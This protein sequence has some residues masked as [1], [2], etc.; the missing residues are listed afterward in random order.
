MVII[1][2][3]ILMSIVPEFSL[4]GRGALRL[5]QL[6]LCSLG[7][8]AQIL[9]CRK[10]IHCTLTRNLKETDL[11]TSDNSSMHLEAQKRTHNGSI[12]YTQVSSEKCFEIYSRSLLCFC[13][14]TFR[15]L[16][17]TNG[18]R[19]SWL[20][21]H[22]KVSVVSHWNIFRDQAA[23]PVFNSNAIEMNLH[24]IAN[25]TQNYIYMNDDL[26]FTGVVKNFFH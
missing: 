13:F 21:N 14:V 5:A 24:R 1:T 11:P 22:D 19:P 26:A 16:K 20:A 9:S 10:T 17:V 7:S 8:T 23:L 6:I 3:S 15:N 4:P 12:I 25:L 2:M 18:E